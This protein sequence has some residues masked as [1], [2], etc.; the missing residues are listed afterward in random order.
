MV[1]EASG[2]CV[3]PLLM[4]WNLQELAVKPF[5]HFYNE[6]FMFVGSFRR[7]LWIHYWWFGI[8]KKLLWTH[9]HTFQWNI[10]GF[11][12]FRRLLR[13]HY[14]WF[15]ISRR[16]LWSN[17]HTFTMKYWWFWNLQEAVVKPWLMVW[18]LQEAAVK[19]FA[20]FSNEIFMF[21]NLWEVVGKSPGSHCGAICTLF[22]WNIYVF[23]SLGRSREAEVTPFTYF[24]YEILMIWN[25]RKAAVKQFI[26]FSKDILLFVLKFHDI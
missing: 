7:L 5:T 9:L 17:L 20:H 14:W 10:N 18:I 11:V 13:I 26:N 15:G 4:A 2:S 24:Y 23:E 6:I 1:L 8:S 19:T 21:W 3:N 16:L 12:S 25:F 22:P